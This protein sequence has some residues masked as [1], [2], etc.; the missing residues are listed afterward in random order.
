[1]EFDSG[2]A[3]TCSIVYYLKHQVVNVNCHYIE[4]FSQLKCYNIVEGL[5][6]DIQGNP[7]L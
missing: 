2:V 7:V 6:D 3:P 4:L 5:D 1:M